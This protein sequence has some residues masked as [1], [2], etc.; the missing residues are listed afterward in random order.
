M[1]IKLENG[2]NRLM[3]WVGGIATFVLILLVLVIAFNVS[4]RYFFKMSSVGIGAEELAW[5]FYSV[6]FLLGIPYALR[7]SSHVRVDLIFDGL[8]AKKKAI[9]DLA[10]SCIFL[11]PFCLIVIWSGWSF[12]M[13]AWG[14]GSRP[15][16][17]GGV[18]KQIVTTGVGEKS[19][20]P[21]GLLNRWIIKGV[22]PLSFFLLLLA[23]LSFMI[24][25]INILLGV[26][27]DDSKHDIHGQVFIDNA[28]NDVTSNKG[29]AS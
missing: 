10:G 4:N 8:S 18:I 12:F 5:H 1:F 21:G 17:I 13:E 3:D 26:Y 15:D 29:E 23:T 11:I 2:I 27:H 25:K 19:Q 24:H 20:D 6:C 16:T 14:L 7:T 28:D 22:I 9:I